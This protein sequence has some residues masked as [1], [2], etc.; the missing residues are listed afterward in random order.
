MAFST[1]QSM[2]QLKTMKV[3]NCGNVKEIVSNE[4]SE[5]GKEMKIV[6]SKLISIELVGLN[7]MRSFC[8]SRE[9]EFD[10]PSLEILIVREC[11]NMEKFSE[12]RP[13]TPKLKNV[14]GVEG[15]EKTRW[16]WEHNLN[17]TIQKV[18]NDKVLA[19]LFIYK[20]I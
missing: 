15:D 5:N 6:F 13:I 14:F 8:S 17:A 18:F 1:A 10:F 7:Y 11:P 3:I 16:Q 9:C 19:H 2:V 4:G 12:R 20:V